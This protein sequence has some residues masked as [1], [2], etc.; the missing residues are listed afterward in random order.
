MAELQVLS[1]RAVQEALKPLAQD[2]TRVTGHAVSFAFAPVG[3]ARKRFEDGEASD[4]VILSAG[5]IAELQASRLLRP[6]CVTL[7]RVGLAVA[8]R[9]GVAAPDISSAHA[10]KDTLLRAASIAASNPAV[11]G[12]AGIYFRR[13]LERL[14]VAEAIN[15][16][17]VPQSGGNDVARAVARGEAEIG[18]TF[19]SE[20]L[21]I[22]GA[23]VAGLL[24]AELQNYTVYAAAIS[25]ASRQAENAAAFIAAVTAPGT[26]NVWDAA[27]VEAA[28][29]RP[30]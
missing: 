28:D 2:F 26:R 27:G 22:V 30:S 9:E 3:V 23:R 21:P 14:G 20:I 25:A 15:A 19:Y 12:S 6:N 10:F 4:I 7:G 1:A 13:L 8:V 17:I 11:G 29:G 16:K 18:V 5:A 24:P